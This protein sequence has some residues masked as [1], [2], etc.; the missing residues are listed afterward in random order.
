MKMHKQLQ[1]IAF[2]I[3]LQLLC[4]SILAARQFSFKNLSVPDGLAQSQV[5]AI[6]Q[7]KK[8]YIWLG[9][10]GGGISKYDG[11]SFTNF[12]NKNGLHNNYIS[13]IKED[14]NGNLWI[15]TR[16]G[17]SIYNG[18]T[19]KQINLAAQ[20]AE[21]FG[22]LFIEK[23]ILL[24]TSAG[25]YLGNAK[26]FKKIAEGE[27]IAATQIEKYNYVATKNCVFSV[28]E[29]KVTPYRAFT[30]KEIQSLGVFQKQLMIGTYG[31]GAFLV[32]SNNTLSALNNEKL[33]KEY[34]LHFMQDDEAKL[35]ISTLNNGICIYDAKN[36][37]YT[38]IN[39]QDG[40]CKNHI[41]YCM[42]D[43]AHNYW[44]GSSGNGFSYSAQKKFIHH[45][46]ASGL[47]GNFIYSVFKDSKNNL[48]VGADVKGISLYASDTCINYNTENGFGNYKIR[49]ITEDAFGNLYFGT[50]GHG[51][52]KYNGATFSLI[53]GTKDNY[54]RYLV[55]D[56]E[57]NIW[58]ATGE[59][60][61]LCIQQNEKVS[62]VIKY[63]KKEGLQ[64]N[65]ISS[66]AIGQNGK[67]WIGSDN[68]GLAYMQNKSIT[69]LY[70]KDLPKHIRCLQLMPNGDLCIGAEGQGVIIL[71][72]TSLVKHS[73]N[74]K[75]SSL[76]IYQLMPLNNNELAIGTERGLSIAQFDKDYVCKSIK[77]FSKNDGFEG[78]ETNLNAIYK[79][80]NGT[81][82]SGTINGLEQFVPNQLINKAAAPI[83]SITQ[84]KVNYKPISLNN[85]STL[86]HNQN[87]ISFEFK[88]ID[89][90]SPESIIYKWKLAGADEQWCPA[91]TETIANYSNLAP[92]QYKF[93]LM[94][95][96]GDS[97]WTAK[98]LQINFEIVPAWWQRT[99]PKL[100]GALL[101][102]ALLYWAVKKR[103]SYIRKKAQEAQKILQTQKDLAEL[104]HTAL[105]LQM[106]PHFLFNAI[107]SI[108]SLI[109][110]NN[111]DKARYY[112]A[113]F[114]KLMRQILNNSRSSTIALSDEI[115]M[116]QNYL[117]IELF[118][119]S[120]A[121]EYSID[122][123]NDVSDE[124][125]IPSMLLQPFVENSLKHGL[126]HL[127]DRKGKID[128]SFYKENNYLVA[129]VKDNGVGRAAAAQLQQQSREPNHNSLALSVIQN[130]LHLL[131]AQNKL[132]IT[133]IYNQDQ[134]IIGTQVKLIL[135]QHDY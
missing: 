16:N 107:N 100:I 32:S 79:E 12:N 103:I 115:D 125:P 3:G 17:V 98:P 53:N 56:K 70:N 75:L 69:K 36:K 5:Y 95:C 18:D 86:K 61:L 88:G 119:N 1:L 65:R 23:N 25:L 110:T 72:D 6:C 97:V 71:R 113:K 111:D 87:R 99:W 74:D 51:L 28:N 73:I 41:R 116:L 7:D 31:A 55:C 14:A 13:V 29:N 132:E 109:G 22:I 59:Q 43:A 90:V 106:N 40:L 48:W 8:G 124:M 80:A 123:A 126:R 81:L 94:A 112:L 76:N 50:E 104:Q 26:V 37:S 68:N 30:A 19:F 101:L 114:S 60:G 117:L 9:T 63:A 77:S 15:G 121:F 45:S 57:N 66:L 10:R 64:E 54:I 92:G 82:W 127:K 52:Y 20:D 42:Q 135:T 67:L 34:V 128:I 134:Q 2:L 96:N 35:W 27:Y 89:F 58:A 85:I 78:I 105:R 38:W 46:Q 122:K 93:M 131:N 49:A 84:V 83:L 133:D 129:I 44:I 108:Q 91:N 4:A 21:V 130:R 62:S 39:E 47:P 33:K 120:I 118:T 102:L 24:A 11:K